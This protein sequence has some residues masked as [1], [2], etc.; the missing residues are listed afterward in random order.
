MP[1]LSRALP[2]I[3]SPG[4]PVTRIVTCPDRLMCSNCGGCPVRK[5]SSETVSEPSGLMVT[6]SG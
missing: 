1:W 3:A 6:F 5:P 4:S 2:P